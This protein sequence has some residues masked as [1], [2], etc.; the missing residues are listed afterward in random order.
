MHCKNLF[1]LL[2]IF[3]I[4]TF[5]YEEGFAKNKS[6]GKGHQQIGGVKSASTGY[7]GL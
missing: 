1:F 4:N 7:Q 6:I 2:L 3:S 5:S